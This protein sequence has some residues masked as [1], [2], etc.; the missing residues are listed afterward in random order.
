MVGKFIA[1]LLRKAGFVYVTEEAFNAHNEAVTKMVLRNKEADF[2]LKES[3][4]QL[5]DKVR[6]LEDRIQHL[7]EKLVE[8]DG[9]ICTTMECVE[10]IRDT[11]QTA[12]PTRQI[13]ENAFGE[14]LNE[15]LYGYQQKRSDDE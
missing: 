14:M 6:P 8:M 11:Q 9:V 4:R 1:W 12:A 3:L 2:W 13:I 15:Y 7:N 10:E 5:N